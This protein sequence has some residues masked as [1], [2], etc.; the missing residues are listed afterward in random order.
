MTS[1]TGAGPSGTP[2]AP[3]R[4]RGGS[5]PQLQTQQLIVPLVAQ[6][7]TAVPSHQANGGEELARA[8]LP[9]RESAASGRPQRKD[10]PQAPPQKRQ[11]GSAATALAV[12][13]SSSQLE[14]ARCQ[15]VGLYANSSMGFGVGQTLAHHG[16]DIQGTE[17]A[18]EQPATVSARRGGHLGRG[19][20]T[21]R[22]KFR[23][24]RFVPQRT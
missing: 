16:T 3:N 12:A 22:S 7:A 23:I 6:T 4:F 5:L 2:L 18:G 17:D 13:S 10:F 24:G 8:L 11:R 19:G 15:L 1:V 21:P 14:T 9:V 20:S